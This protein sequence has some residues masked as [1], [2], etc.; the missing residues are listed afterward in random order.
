MSE[1]LPNATFVGFPGTPVERDDKNSIHVFGE[2]SDVYDIRQ[3]VEDGATKPLYYESRIV[4]LSVDDAGAAAGQAEVERVAAANAAGEDA[5]DRI[6][7]PLEALVGP[8]E[9][10]QPLG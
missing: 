6:R 10:L 4:K 3:A 2:Y 9:R 5:I 8:P 7:I 1:A